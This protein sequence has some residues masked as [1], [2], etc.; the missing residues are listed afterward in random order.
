M[1][2]LLDSRSLLTA[3]DL[4]IHASINERLATLHRERHGLWA[5]LRRFLC[6]TTGHTMNLREM[7]EAQGWVAA[8]FYILQ[9][10]YLASLALT[11]LVCPA[12]GQRSSS[13]NWHAWSLPQPKPRRVLKRPARHPV[14]CHIRSSLCHLAQRGFPPRS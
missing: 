10:S 11:L 7:G 2:S 4:R 12:L 5:K 3:K 9:S 13:S 1:I 8:V 14:L 6:T